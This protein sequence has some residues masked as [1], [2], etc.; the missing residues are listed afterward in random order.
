MSLSPSLVPYRRFTK[1]EWEAQRDDE[2]MTL[3][4]QEVERLR[5]FSDPISL[6]EAERTY[7]PL[8][9]LLSLFVVGVQ[10]L[11]TVTT[12][13]LNSTEKKVPFV[14]G[15]AGSV[16][17]GKSTTARILQA[18]LQRWPSSPKVDLVTTDGFL[19]P[20]AILS[21]RNL[22]RRKGYPESYDRVRLVNFLSDIKSGRPSVPV[23]L[24]SH[25]V[26]DVIDGAAAIVNQP[27]ILIV[28]GLN[29][30]QPRAAYPPDSSALF[31]SDFI[32]FSI[33]VDARV[34]DLES[35]Y[36]ARFFRLRE[37]AF[38]DSRSYFRRYAAMDKDEAGKFGLD[39]WR[40]INLP[41]LIENIQ[42]TRSRAH[43]ILRKGADHLVQEVFLRPI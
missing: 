10:T 17:V 14:I 36:M 29:I 7:L 37:T 23:P 5:S 32:D 16:A 40:N 34:E 33:Y 35:W 19:Y 31:A 9:R 4:A 41:N 2:R 30:L 43:L 25:L 21:A 24:Y 22:M 8:S 6:Q 27:D 38:G 28:E 12:R 11:H 42:P 39:N 3:S 13:F 1:A 15:V 18:L 20:N 26:Y